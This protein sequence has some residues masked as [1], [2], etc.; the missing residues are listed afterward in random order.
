M[1]LFELT[2]SDAELSFSPFVWRTRMALA[3]KGITPERVATR[4]L[5]KSA[6]APSGSKTVPVIE[7]NG[8][9]VS[10]AWDI[11]CYLEKTYPDAP[12]LFGGP[13]GMG[14]AR[15]I[16]SWA[17]ATILRGL[18]PMLAADICACLDAE[19]QAYFRSTREPHLGCSLEEAK[20][21]RDK[22][23]IALRKALDP[24]RGTL[25]HQPFL[26]GETPSYADYSVFGPFV[27]AHCCTDFAIL[28]DDD[29]IT[30]WR[31]RMFDLFDGLARTAKRAV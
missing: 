15:F 18:F 31:A 16:D 2:G 8:E 14:Q 27:W 29:I 10:Q 9:W 4:F 6:F 26:G 12:S 24:M 1:R 17:D 28:E 13:L 21:G 7:D 19:D 5:D 11:A 30:Q 23:V 25:R 20:A 3:H 22:A